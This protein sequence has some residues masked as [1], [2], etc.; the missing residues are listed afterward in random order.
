MSAS[1][2][3]P[4][5]PLLEVRTGR[6]KQLADTNRQ[7]AIDKQARQGRV[8]LGPL[9]LAGDEQG[10]PL[11]HGGPDMAALHYAA[12]H[13]A[14]WRSELPDSA[15][16]L[17]PGGFGENLVSE[18][19]E[20]ST[21]CIGDLVRIG[22]ALLQV[23][24]PRQP[25]FKLNHRFG[26]PTMSRRSQDSG[27]TGWFYRVIEA[28]EV[29]AGDAIAVLDRPHAK[30]TIRRVQH[31]LYDRELALDGDLL[32]ELIDLPPLAEAIRAVFRKR[33]AAAAIESSQSRLHDAE[34]PV[35]PAKAG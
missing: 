22:G 23:T 9:G 19:L 28:G 16:R 13:Y 10:T 30:W 1:E 18:G 29:A 5:T 17:V 27:R 24:Q 26:D 2:I 35:R 3:L 14:L 11:I 21:I 6:V 4:P 20:E 31:C 34:N 15:D 32:R 12:Q 25:C 7:S 8:M 33:L